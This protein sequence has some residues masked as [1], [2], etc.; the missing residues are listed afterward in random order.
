MRT[1]PPL[2]IGFN[3][4]YQ[5]GGT[6]NQTQQT[7]QLTTSAGSVNFA[8]TP[9]TAANPSGRPWLVATPLDG[10]VTASAPVT[11]TVGLDN[12]AVA[13]LPAGIAATHVHC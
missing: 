1:A 7:I 2:A 3:Y 10:V 5:I 4:N 9:T 8:V 11:F 12:A 13:S 6:A